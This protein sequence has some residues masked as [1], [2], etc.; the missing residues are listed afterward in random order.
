MVCHTGMSYKFTIIVYRYDQFIDLRSL[1]TH[2]INQIRNNIEDQF[3]ANLYDHITSVVEVTNQHK[4]GQL[5]MDTEL[6]DP[7]VQT[8][9]DFWTSPRMMRINQE[10]QVRFEKVSEQPF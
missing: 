7:S 9:L 4:Y 1:T 3:N 10:I 8:F 6:D 2:E 5:S